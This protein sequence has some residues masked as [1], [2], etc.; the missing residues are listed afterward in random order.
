M[1]GA[2]LLLAAACAP[3]P[4][5]APS[6]PAP[7]PTPPE[8]PPPAPACEHIVSIE[9]HKRERELVAECARGARV[10]FPVALG[11]D[12]QGTKRTGGDWRTPEGLYHIVSDTPSRFHRFL[13]LDYP[14]IGD[15]QDAYL[16]GRISGRDYRRIAQAHEQGKLPP[17]HTALGGGI[18]LHGEGP[19]WQGY[20]HLLDWTYG[21]IALTDDEIDFLAERVA[22]G[23]PVR[24]LADTPLPAPPPEPGDAPSS[25]DV[26]DAR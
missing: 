26:P 10:L 14:S 12:P 6:V 19:D 21:C 11:R 4:P 15:A 3:A 17:Q 7:A 9:I 2:V 1:A 20:S 13:L 8:T 5:P 18:G 22:P 24:I 23:T 25:E 16:D